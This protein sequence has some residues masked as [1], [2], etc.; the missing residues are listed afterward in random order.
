MFGLQIRGLDTQPATSFRVKCKP[1]ESLQRHESQSRI[2][3]PSVHTLSVMRFWT[4]QIC[5][6]NEQSIVFSR[7]CATPPPI[8]RLRSPVSRARLRHPAKTYTWRSWLR[9]RTDRSTL[10]ASSLLLDVEPRLS[11][12]I[13]LITANWFRRCI[14]FLNAHLRS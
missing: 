3:N 8:L 2:V 9:S 12:S 11:I 14:W 10:D 1:D 6:A 13:L 4:L 7:K 5:R